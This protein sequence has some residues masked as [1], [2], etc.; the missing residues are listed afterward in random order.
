MKETD[1]ADFITI[2]SESLCLAGDA[3]EHLFGLTPTDLGSSTK[4]DETPVTQADFLAEQ[5][6]AERILAGFPTLP[7][8]REETDSVIPDADDIVCLIDPLDGTSSFERGFST[9]GMQVGL[10]RRTNN[11]GELI[12]SVIYEPQT[13]RLWQAA[14]SCGAFMSVY[15]RNTKILK[16][17]RRVS[18][19]TPCQANEKSGMLIYD[20]A[21]K[22]RNIVPDQAAKAAILTEVLPL[23][24]RVRMIG[25]LALQFAYVA[26]GYAEAT[27]ADAVGGPYDLC[28]HLLV[29]EAGGRSS[30]LRRAP[31]DVFSCEV[32]LATNGDCHDRLAE[33]L[34]RAYSRIRQPGSTK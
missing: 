6:I 10:V 14:R 23:F 1:I 27:V 25:S 5:V 4:K 13:G 20:A 15:D 31:I 8:I 32:A 9:Y 17:G 19:S 26:S 16:E 29:D 28:G 22:F 7:L 3:I 2:A 33:V 12:A 30:D 34:E 18:V 24:R 11:R 21:I